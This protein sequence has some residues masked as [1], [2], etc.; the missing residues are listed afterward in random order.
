MT[1]QP[2]VKYRHDYKS[3]DYTITDINLDFALDAQKTTVTAISQVK[4]QTA[5]VTPLVLDG[6]DLTLVSISVDGQAWPHYQLQDNSLVI[7][8]LPAHFTLTIVNDI[9]PATNSALE[10][11]YL[12]G[13]ALCTQCEAEGFRHIT[14]YLD[15]PDVLAR[16]TTRIVADKALY[17]YLLSNGN[18]VGQGVLDDGRHW[19]KWE[20][21]FPKPCYLFALVAGDFDVL[22]DKFITRSGREVALELFVDRGNLDRADWAMTSLKNSMKWDETRFGLEYDLDIYMIVAVD[23]FNMGAMENK[24]LNVFNSKYVLAKAE[25]ATDKDYLNIEAVIG[26]EY[27]HNWTGNRVTCRDWFQ[28]SLKEGLTVFR[29]QEF[30]SDLGSRSVNR[31][32]N[33]R[34]M[35]AAQFA[36]DASPMAHAIRPDKVIEMNNFYTLTVYEKGSEVIRMMHTLLGEQQFQAGMQLYF[37]RH[38]GSAAT[39]DDFVQAM[40]DASNVDLSL[41]R[42]WYSQSGTPILTVR[43]DYDAE[44]QQ[45]HLHVSQ[46]TLPTAD[47]PEKLPLHIPLDIELYDSKGNVIALQRN[48]LPVHHVLNVT[49][50]EQTFTFDNVEHTP[51]PS[52]LREFSAPVKLDY[53]YSDQQL[54]FLMQHARNEFFR[55][56][57]AQSLLA[58]YIKLNVAKYQ[59][60]QPLSL[61]NHVADAFRAILLDENLDPA[62]AA[63]ILTL[64]SENEI[65]ELFTTIDPQAISAVHEAITRCLANELSDEL[66]AV[67]VANITPEYRIEHSDIAKRALRNTCL[68]YLAFGDAEFANKLVSSQYHQADNMT[69][70][71]A[72]LAAAV[73]AQLPCRDELLAAFDVRWS[74]DGLVMDKWFALQATSPAVDVLA[75]VRA[76][77]KHPAFSLSNPNRTRS[78]IGS[79]ASGNPAA[80]HATDGSGYQFLVEIL[81]DLNTRNPQVAARLIEPLIR[82]KRYDSGRQTLMRQALEQLKKLDNLSGDLYEKIT[83]ALAA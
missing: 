73:A 27:F 50:A 80:F 10:G 63:Q 3:P 22:R 29:D 49:E 76:L 75:Q 38:D 69:D 1:Q 12:S 11:L 74:H 39:C 42:R 64:P 14:Y 8:Q 47:Q 20:D 57:A 62:L 46:K 33:V 78:L 48:G 82:L 60:K 72:A 68:N 15:R 70:S 6:E 31:I 54:T 35:R 30:S 17:P 40:E 4:R 45:Y 28:L 71:L 52:L 66:L 2:Q 53:T 23:F 32:E 19:V 7:E 59:Q 51:I 21:P 61:P 9:H 16:F 18:R 67:Y 65:A 43:D 41:F 37:E 36:E 81:S 44:K 56:D 34:V 83:K 77:L 25:T 5:D 55:W 26:H 58:T 79:F 13:E 24:G